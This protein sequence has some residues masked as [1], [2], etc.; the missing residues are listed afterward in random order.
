MIHAAGGYTAWSDKHPVY[1]VVSGPTGTSSPSNVDD[2]Y[3]P[4]VN[5]NRSHCRASQRSQTSI[6]LRFPHA[7]GNDWTTDFDAI[8]CY[9]QLKVNAVVNW[10]NG[11]THLGNAQRSCAGYFRNELPG[12]QRRTEADRGRSQGRLHGRRGRS[13]PK[14]LS[15]IEFVDAAIGQ[16][17][18]ALENARPSRFDHDHHHRQARPVA[19]RSQP[20]LPD[21]RTLWNERHAALRSHRSA[22]SRQLYGDPNNGLGST[23]DDISQLWLTNSADT[24]NAVNALETA[25]VTSGSNASAIGLG[26]IFYGA[27]L[28]T[29]FNAPGV[30]AN[31]GPCCFLRPGGD[32]RTP[33]IIVMPN[34][35]VVYTGS[36]K[37]QSEHG[38]FA[39]DDTNVM[40]LVSNPGITAR[41]VTSFV[42]TDQVA[43]TILQLLGLNPAA[44][45]AVRTEGTPVLPGLSFKE[46]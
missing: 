2:Y 5:S 3:A 32:P 33:D 44:L 37:K 46:E 31:P 28:T 30:P 25:G 8:Q 29:M 11:K 20:L 13:H 18:T 24:V 36:L 1:A 4:E 38:G 19:D 9:D 35:G 42:E 12:R 40:L 45:D 43:P 41:T 6:A 27:S 39:H 23:E 14:M 26:Q 22:F 10:I 17:V 21:S 15:E 7:T 34:V 16:M